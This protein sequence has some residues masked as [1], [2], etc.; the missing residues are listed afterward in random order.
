MGGGMTSATSRETG[1]DVGSDRNEQPGETRKSRRA[2][3]R[4]RRAQ[5]KAAPDS[6]PVRR[7]RRWPWIVV[8]VTVSALLGGCVYAVFFSPLL[9]VRSVTI[10]G[11]DDTLTAQ[12]R[13]VVSVPTG[14][15]LAR[16]D[17][18]AVA[19]TVEGVSEVAAVEVARE[20]P[21]TVAVTVTPRVPVAVTSANGQLWLL[22]TGGDPYLTVDSPPP[23]LVTVQL[24]APGR[25]DPATKAAVSVVAALTPDFRSQ[26]AVLSARTEFDVELT[27]I[28]R[29]KVIW[30][31]PTENP[32]KMQMLPALLAARDG[33]EYD[34][35]DPTL[36]TVR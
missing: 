8:L 31:E 15:P 1:R 11:V 16:V 20:W 26:V 2:R 6:R 14:T 17:L 3:R 10:K 33:T 30:G 5:G 9:A 29:K 13:A 36:A 18:D 23:G 21:D 4:A 32:Q 28:D 22:D 7:R 12:V 34:I 25:N 24:A 27:L 35:T 19:A